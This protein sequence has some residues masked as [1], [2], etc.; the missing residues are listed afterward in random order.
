M[1]HLNDT[2]IVAIDNGECGIGFCT[3]S[4]Y[5][6]QQAFWE[7]PQ[8]KNKTIEQV[9][10][11][12]NYLRSAY[13]ILAQLEAQDKYYPIYKL[14][15]TRPRHLDRLEGYELGL[16]TLNMHYTDLRNLRKKKMYT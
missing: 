8:S 9:L 12:H 11:K 7:T 2:A 3:V 16:M 10:T 1:N 6:L 5:V 4:D 14:Y 13:T 15:G